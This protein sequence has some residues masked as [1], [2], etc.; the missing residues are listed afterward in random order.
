MSNIYKSSS[1]GGGGVVSSASGTTPIEVNGLSGTPETG[2]VVISINNATTTTPGA[3]SFNPT[4]FTVTSGEVSLIGG[5]TQPAIQTLT[6][7][8]GTTIT[9]TG[10]PEN[11]QL[12]GHVFENSGASKFSTILAGTHIVNINPMSSSRWIVDPLGFNGTHTTI[13]SAI[14]SA[15]SG[16][17]IFIMPGTYTENLTLKA[18]VNLSACACDAGSEAST[19]NVV[20]SGRMTASYLGNASISGLCL[21]TNSDF[22]LACTGSSLTQLF[23]F[24]CNINALNN[25]AINVSNSGGGH[26]W[27]MQCNGTLRTTGIAFFS[28]TG[29]MEP[30]LFGC[31]FTDVG[32]STT[33]STFSVNGIEI[34][35]SVFINALTSTGTA[36]FAIYNS[37]INGAIIHGGSGT[38]LLYNN[39]LLGATNSSLSVGTGATATVSNCIIDSTNTNAISGLG[40]LK[41]CNLSFTNSSS[42]INTT[43]QVPLVKSNDAVKVTTPGAYPYTT[44]GNDYVIA[45]NT[46]AARTIN[47]IAS[48]VTGQSYRIKDATGTAGTFNIT[49]TPNAGTIDGVATYIINTNYGS[50]DVVY[51][52]S[53]WSI[54]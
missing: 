43:T 5:T 11:I 50:V 14:T 37:Y 3:A 36:G 26:L 49:V 23:L 48:P 45:V 31:N 20:I 18:G 27:F 44:L 46:S 1:G 42:I 2:A 33:A 7:D 32:G 54:V 53:Q 29:S 6:D 21:Q 22:C 8:V 4:Q 51:N 9:P 12:S 47:L 24:G 16:D 10:T 35:D 41:Y 15:F 52:G 28:N 13:G 25:T 34:Y 39:E 40:T 38:C 17:T 30:K 19:P